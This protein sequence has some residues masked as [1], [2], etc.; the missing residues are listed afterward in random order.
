MV[1]DCIETFNNPLRAPSV[2]QNLLAEIFLLES[3]SF[4]LW[5]V[6]KTTI[7]KVI[8]TDSAFLRFTLFFLYDLLQGYDNKLET[9]CGMF[10]V[11]FDI[12]CG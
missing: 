3:L 1:L 9:L 5:S 11:V 7:T 2:L 8:T 6:L 4:Y 10:G 12:H